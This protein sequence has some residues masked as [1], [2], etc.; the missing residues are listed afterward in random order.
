MS[1]TV[2]DPEVSMRAL[3]SR[4]VAVIGGG[5]AGL[6]HALCLRDCG[7]SVVW[8]APGDE[9]AAQAGRHE[10][11]RVLDLD[12]ACEQSDVI[13]LLQADHVQRETYDAVIAPHVAPG[14]VLVL[15]SGFNVAWDVIDV[16]PRLDVVVV[17][18][19]GSPHEVREAF[20]DGRGIPCVMAVAQDASGD[21]AETARAYAKALGGLRGG[22]IEASLKH[23]TTASV[24]GSHAV[25]DGVMLAVLEAGAS[26]LTEAGVPS[27]LAYRAVI[28]H[29]RRALDHVARD[30]ASAYVREGSDWREYVAIASG[31][32]IV[33]DR[34]KS[35]MKAA[36]HHIASGALAASFLEDV[37]KG[38]MLL[39]SYRGRGLL[40]SLDALGEGAGRGADLRDTSSVKSVSV[41]AVEERVGT[42][43]YLR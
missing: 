2:F 28:D 23:L 41:N 20:V 4:F 9:Q 38:G 15:A 25:V 37:E 35:Q 31:R 18:S 13:V 11:L 34:V 22:G 21:A 17:T 30:G 26:V 5:Q 19:L 40:E 1:A 39:E 24:F 43:N 42:S 7:V 8:G 36:H 10:G 3:A 32:H 29:A 12:D 27:T 14:D 33:S 16:D 6:T